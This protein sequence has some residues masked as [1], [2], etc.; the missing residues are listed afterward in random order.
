MNY[1]L[2]LMLVTELRHQGAVSRT[3]MVRTSV[4]TVVSAVVLFL[5]MW[6][7]RYNSVRAN[8]NWMN[9]RWSQIKPVYDNIISMQNE[10]NNNKKLLAEL[11]GWTAA[12]ID[13]Q[14]P[15][16][17]V[18]HIVPPTIQLTRVN[19]W[20]TMEVKEVKPKD[21]PKSAAGASPVAPKG[22][23][24]SAPIRTFNIIIDGKASG[25]LADETVVQFVR[26]IRQSATLQPLLAGIKLQGI[27]RESGAE[28]ESETDAVRVFTIEAVTLPREQK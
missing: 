1:R 4:L 13:W 2:N 22:K 20:G 17:E 18:P 19:I 28:N 27:R 12:R 26:T 6:M 10:L 15:L 3:F 25:T 21:L 23:L 5:L 24:F 14:S 8:V 9:E 16:Q 7:V 11:Q